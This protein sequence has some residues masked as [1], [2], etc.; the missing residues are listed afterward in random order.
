MVGPQKPELIKKIMDELKKHPEGIWI[1]KLARILDEP[2][3]TVHRYVTV[4]DE[5]YP[6]DKI[7]II[8][9]LPQELGG[10]M[11]IKLRNL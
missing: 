5:G 10:R 8:E 2:V 3:M 6:G 11:I 4:K 1:R 9:Q 7:E